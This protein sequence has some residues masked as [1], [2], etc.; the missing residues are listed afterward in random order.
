MALGNLAV[1]TSDKDTNSYDDVPYESFSYPQ[2][3][4]EQMYTVAKLFGLT[5]PDFRK[6]RVLE[7]GCASG[8][9]L[10][11]LAI[12]YPDSEYTGIDLSGEQIDQ[13]I[14]HK[15]ELGL[16]NIHFERKD[17]MDVTKKYGAYD[18]IIVHGILSWVPDEVA[19]KIF[20]ICRDNLSENGMAVISYNTLPGWNFVKSLREM[21]LYHCERFNDSKE[22]IAQA[23]MFLD[24][25]SDNAGS[26]SAYK[27]FID[28][29]REILSKV[30]DTY[31]FHD[32]L[33]GHNRQFYF[34]EIAR[35]L[36]ERNMQYLGDS[37]IS[38]MFV[39][40]LPKGAMEKL[41][42]VND[43]VR[44]E[45]Y[46]DFINNRRFRTTI[47]TRAGQKISRG[48]NTS[49]IF[50][51]YLSS[52][53]TPME[54]N[55]KLSDKMEFKAGSRSFTTNS[56]AASALMLEIANTNSRR[57]TMDEVMESA[58]A[59]YG[60]SNEKLKAAAT[61]SGMRLVMAGIFNIHSSRPD[62]AS[63]VSEKPEAFALARYQANFANTDM[64]TNIYGEAI[65]SDV[66]INHLVRYLDGTNDRKALTKKLVEHA[67]RG[68]ITIRKGK[69]VISDK[70]ELEKVLGPSAAKRLEVLVKLGILVK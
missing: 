66:F 23:R 61:E 31:L 26:N 56:R 11:P 12:M 28:S 4:P 22:K 3:H 15:A 69:K 40:N 30:N 38:S 32:H 19:D 43:I 64:L 52:P 29:E 35:M 9:N 1:N 42:G 51:F 57:F 27:Q 54:A 18:Y 62:L 55:A 7:L 49:Q 44:Q 59:K 5:A 25:L 34:H 53:I 24:F 10:L 46:M 68:E 6:A 41:K 67:T 58:S 37:S 20:D 36:N 2:T 13:A 45:Q 8:G 48:I 21:M 65:K 60:I 50:D 33:E 16:S 14:H 63:D 70:K 17:I 39:G 47:I